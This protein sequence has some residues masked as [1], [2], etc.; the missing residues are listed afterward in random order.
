LLTPALLSPTQ[1]QQ[2][3]T[4]MTRSE[5]QIPPDEQID[6]KV[7]VE[8]IKNDLFPKAKSVLGKDEWDVFGMIYKD[9]IKC[10]IGRIALRTVSDSGRESC[11]KNIWMTAL[12]RKVQKKALVQKRSTMHMV[13][14]CKFTGNL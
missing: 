11:M 13:M 6:L 3:E 5:D 8:H 14:Q 1:K 12:T 9:H 4:T 2:F 7:L 10:C